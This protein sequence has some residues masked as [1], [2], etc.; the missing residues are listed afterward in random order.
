MKILITG[1]SGGLGEYLYKSLN[2]YSLNRQTNFNDISQHE[3]D[4]IVHCAFN[5]KNTVDQSE[6]V[7]YINDNVFLT[8]KLIKEVKSKKFIFISSIDVYPQNHNRNED[9]PIN[10]NDI[11]NIYGKTKLI[12]EEIVKQHQNYLIL[13]CCGIIGT[14][15]IPKS[16]R[17]LLETKKTTLTQTSTVNYI[18]QKTILDII[19]YNDITNQIVNIA[20][21]LSIQIQDLESIIYPIN[22]GS[23]EY[24]IGNIKIDK[25]KKYFPNINNNSSKDV[26][27]NVINS[28]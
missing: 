14:N 21:D 5:T 10:I 8:K 23:Y 4:L 26:L 20:S 2:C 9:T 13:R 17:N 11:K 1:T 19:K 22:Y 28:I 3:F 16:I 12:S 24:D 6:L 27:L 15:K 18:N 7:S 25:F